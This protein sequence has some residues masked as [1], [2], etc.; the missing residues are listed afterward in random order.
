M[1]D[2]RRELRDK[3]TYHEMAVFMTQLPPVVIHLM[4][5]APGCHLLL[6][7]YSGMPLDHVE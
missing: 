2:Q 1:L 6:L 7:V 5:T 4:L 3:T